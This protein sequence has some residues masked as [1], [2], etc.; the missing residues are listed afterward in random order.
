MAA[1]VEI[2]NVHK[3]GGEATASPLEARLAQRREAARLG[4]I[5]AGDLAHRGPHSR[6]L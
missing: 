4:R 2:A 3:A 1:T 6:G 5:A